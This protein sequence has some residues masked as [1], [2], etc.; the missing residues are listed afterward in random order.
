MVCNLSEEQTVVEL[1]AAPREL[2]LANGYP[3]IDG[4]ALDVPGEFFAIVRV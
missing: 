3:R 4:A 1:D 2:L